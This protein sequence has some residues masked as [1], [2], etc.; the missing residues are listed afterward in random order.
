[1]VTSTIVRLAPLLPLIAAM[2][3]FNVQTVDPG[4]LFID[5]F[6]DGDIAPADPTFNDWRCYSINPPGQD[7]SCA[8]VPMPGDNSSFALQLQATIQDPV[9]QRQDHGGA[10]LS[11]PANTPVDFTR[12]NMIAFDFSFDDLALP[13]GA[14][15]YAE[16]GCSTVLA[17]NSTNPKNLYILHP[18]D[19]TVRGWNRATLSL[20][21]FAPPPWVPIGIKGGAP[22]C[23][24]HVDSVRVSVDADLGDGDT[25]SFTLTIDDLEL[26]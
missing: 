1:V 15:L 6:E 12:F 5:D 24:S 3:C 8:P 23:L 11:T 19:T 21:E 2:G 7:I 17:S 20:S 14:L 13:T 25:K 16:L 10:A 9:N 18:V 22:A 4:P 26:L